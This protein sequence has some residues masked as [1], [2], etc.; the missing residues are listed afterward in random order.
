MNEI[1]TLRL[2]AALMSELREHLFRSDDDEHGAVVGASVSQ[3]PRGLRLLARRLFLARDGTDYI[4]GERG[5]RMLTPEFVLRCVHA[6][7]EEGLAYLAVHN[8]PG[9]DSV[10]FSGVD[11]ASHRRG[12]PALL[13]I[14]DGPPAGAL[15]F[16]ENAVAADIWLSQ[17]RQIELDHAVVTGRTPRLL[18]PTPRGHSATDARYDR[19][20]RFFGDRGQEILAAQKVGIVGA[21]GVGSLI[22]E[23]LARLGVGHLVVI[24]DDRI[25][26]T[27]SS[28]VVGARTTDWEPRWLPV[29][30]ARRLGWKPT[31]K[32]EI[33][34]RVALEANPDIRFDAVDADV[35]DPHAADRLVDCDAIFLAADT[36][37]ARHVVN[38]ICHRYLVPVWQAG[39]KVQVNTSSGEVDDVFSVIR[40]LVPGQSCLWC[41]ELIDR[42]R[43][44]EEAELPEQRAAQRY[45]GEVPNPSVITLNAVAAAHA[46]ND[47][48]LTTVGL[49][50]HDTR[51]EWARHHPLT[52]YF[53]RMTT[54]S[55]PDCPQCVRHLAAGPLEELPVKERNY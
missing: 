51:T 40:H 12:Y 13:D 45:I 16:A 25:E 19:Q 46:V 18:F 31:L 28:R 22:N 10:A 39:T 34:E 44:A 38:A 48:L 42:A 29:N 7:A 11:M 3:T 2:P 1:S 35:V 49:V 32:V 26:D 33:A 50:E 23:Y 5:F 17:E 37:R 55:E 52:G 54:G 36:V 41:S 24:D 8:H 21:G 47:Y 6:C 27:N 43:L 4:P 30:L 14:L 53:A 9:V 20:V 15:V